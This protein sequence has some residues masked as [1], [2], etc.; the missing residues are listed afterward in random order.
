MA[1]YKLI[2]LLLRNLNCL[3]EVIRQVYLL[4]IFDVV[5]AGSQETTLAT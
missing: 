2:L 4:A 3:V 1:S 5:E